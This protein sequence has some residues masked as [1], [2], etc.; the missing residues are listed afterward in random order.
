MKR[1]GVILGIALL[2]GGGCATKPSGE[3]QVRVDAEPD[4][5]VAS[6]LLFDPPVILDEPPLDLSRES[7]ERSAFVGYEDQTVT[8][9]YIHIDDRQV[10]QGGHGRDRYERRSLIDRFGTSYR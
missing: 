9:S 1:T 5:V 2:F 3:T 4:A 10:S 6:A 8:F 7:R